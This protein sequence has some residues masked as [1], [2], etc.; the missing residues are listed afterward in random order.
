[1]KI[2]A[3]LRRYGFR[4]WYERQLYESHAYL[5]TAFLSLIL[6]AT[7]AEVY[8]DDETAMRRL[9]V[10]VVAAA[11][12][13]LCLFAWRRFTALLFRAE[14]LAEQATCTACRS[15]AKFDVLRAQPAPDAPSG[16][17]LSVRCRKCCCEWVI[18]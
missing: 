13:V 7:A 5:I 10:L 3:H 14:A 8:P 9:F 2:S 15:Y 1:M 18:G 16:E 11:A 6:V 17:R 4:R 12:A